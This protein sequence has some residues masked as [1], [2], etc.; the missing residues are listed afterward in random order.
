L[1]QSS[2]N[3]SPLSLTAPFQHFQPS[4]SALQLKEGKE[5]DKSMARTPLTMTDFSP[6][7]A[8]HSQEH[9][10][11]QQD[12]EFTQLLK[13]KLNNLSSQNKS[14]DKS[15]PKS[16]PKSNPKSPLRVSNMHRLNN[17]PKLKQKKLQEQEVKEDEVINLECSEK[18]CRFFI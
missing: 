4:R 13:H 8:N 3:I 16:I 1:Q 15:A 12:M 9:E 17:T 11:A 7:V 2:Q 14:I 5:K 10:L 6:N 18:L